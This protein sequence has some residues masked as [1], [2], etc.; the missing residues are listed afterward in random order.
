MQQLRHTENN[1]HHCY[2]DLLFY[3]YFFNHSRESIY[4]P[5][6]FKPIFEG[7]NTINQYYQEQTRFLSL[8]LLNLFYNCVKDIHKVFQ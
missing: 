4:D 1:Y 5:P 2:L 6:L 7:G 8:V 3:F